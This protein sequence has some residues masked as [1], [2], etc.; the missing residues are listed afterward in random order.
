LSQYFFGAGMD[1]IIPAELKN[2]VIY[3]PNIGKKDDEI[4]KILFFHPQD[5]NP[6][7]QLN[8]C[9]FF[10]ALVNFSTFLNFLIFIMLIQIFF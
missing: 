7:E 9:G 3:N 10:E 4:E 6:D 2:F 8:L 1:K 5:T